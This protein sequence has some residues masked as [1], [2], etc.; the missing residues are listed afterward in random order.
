M[1]L[2]YA[3]IGKTEFSLLFIISVMFFQKQ[4]LFNWEK[5]FLYLVET[6]YQG[7]C[8]ELGRLFSELRHLPPRLTIWPHIVEK[9]KKAWIA[10]LRPPNMCHSM[11]VHTNQQIKKCN[12]NVSEPCQMLFS[13]LGS[14]VICVGP[15]TVTPH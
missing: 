10:I 4:L 5:F 15:S 9:E 3:L 8:S 12:K 2:L 1:P 6:L 13:L 11:H 14:H 7:F